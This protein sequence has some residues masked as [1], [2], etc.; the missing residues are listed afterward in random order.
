MDDREPSGFTLIELLITV[1]LV[2]LLAGLAVPAMGQFIDR[3]RLRGAAEALVQELRYAREYAITRQRNIFFTADAGA[4]QQW[5]Y[6]WSESPELEI[7]ASRAETMPRSRRRLA[8]NFPSVSLALNRSA[9]RYR[10]Q[11]N[12][13]R[14][15]ATANSVILSNRS[16]ELRVIV[17]PLG[18]VRVCS[19]EISGYH[20]C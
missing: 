12:P 18:R 19:T 4:P 1:T 15:T 13:V 14:G 6:G 10:I 20:P 17:S 11:F 5:C 2:A 9:S 16:G 7:C 3:H 8:N